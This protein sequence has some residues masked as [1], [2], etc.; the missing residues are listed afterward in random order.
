MSRLLQKYVVDDL[1]AEDLE[2][3]RYEIEAI[4]LVELFDRILRSNSALLEPGGQ[5][6]I[7][8]TG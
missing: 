4:D 5:L 8:R 2:P 1:P 6:T 7:R 3:L